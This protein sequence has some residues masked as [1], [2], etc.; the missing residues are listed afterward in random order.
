M[1]IIVNRLLM[2]K[3]IFKFKSFNENIDF[4]TRFCLANIPNGFGATESRELYLT[5][6]VYDFSL[7][8]NAI[9]KSD[10]LNIHNYLMV[11]NIIKQCSIVLN[12]WLL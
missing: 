7:N 9:D 11:E 12:K 3:E 8:Y 5:E 10:I 4:S 1:L 6:N 2:E